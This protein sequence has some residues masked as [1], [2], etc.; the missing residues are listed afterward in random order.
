MEIGKARRG[1][2]ASAGGSCGGYLEGYFVVICFTGGFL[3][4]QSV[5]SEDKSNYNVM[6]S[7]EEQEA[8]EH[9]SVV[10]GT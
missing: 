2:R 1:R 7:M 10:V 6:T 5:Y 4:T 3:S 8:C 9:G